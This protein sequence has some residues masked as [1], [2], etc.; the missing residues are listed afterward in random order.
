MTRLSR[1][2]PKDELAL[3]RALDRSGVFQTDEEFSREWNGPRRVLA[4]LDRDVLREWSGPRAHR[5]PY[6]I[7]ATTWRGERVLVSNDPGRDVARAPDG[8][9]AVHAQ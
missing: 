2:R 8:P 3:G 9:E 4:V 5:V 6:R 1:V 7:L